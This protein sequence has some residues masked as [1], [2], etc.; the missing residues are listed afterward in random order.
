[1]PTFYNPSSKTNH[2]PL[3]YP[4]NCESSVKTSYAAFAAFRLLPTAPWPVTS[5]KSQTIQ[6]GPRPVARLLTACCLPTL[7]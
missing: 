6:S 7:I 2:L 4:R 1:V 5:P 3:F